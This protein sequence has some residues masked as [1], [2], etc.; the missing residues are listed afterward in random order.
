MKVLLDPLLTAGSYAN[1]FASKMTAAAW[2]TSS[3]VHLHR[4]CIH[5]TRS[6]WNDM[7]TL[8]C[9]L[10]QCFSAYKSSADSFPSNIACVLWHSI[11]E[12]YASN[13]LASVDSAV[14]FYPSGCC[15]SSMSLVIHWS[16][17]SS[18]PQLLGTVEVHST[19]YIAFVLP[20]AQAEDQSSSVI[21]FFIYSSGPLVLPQHRAVTN[22]LCWQ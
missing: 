14:A 6:S 4:T 15:N 18:L 5:T 7:T 10:W 21:I 20:N 1:R 12:K 2:G 17:C 9:C 22:Q 3:A 13:S 11:K 16:L 8:S 19:V